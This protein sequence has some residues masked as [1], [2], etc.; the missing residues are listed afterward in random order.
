MMLLVVF[1]KFMMC[2]C[3]LYDAQLVSCGA[4]LVASR[5]LRWNVRELVCFVLLGFVSISASLFVSR[6]YTLVCGLLLLKIRVI[7]LYVCAA[8]LSALVCLCSCGCLVI[9][10]VEVIVSSLLRFL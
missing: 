1:E 8:P 10:F 3:L 7:V 5:S 2:L 9:V 4:N 6:L